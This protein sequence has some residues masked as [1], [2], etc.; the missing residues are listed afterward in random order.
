MKRMISLSLAAMLAACSSAPPQQT[1]MPPSVSVQPMPTRDIDGLMLYYEQLEKIPAPGLETE[2]QNTSLA[3]SKTGSDSSRMRLSL[4]LWLPGTP[5]RNPQAALDLL[6]TKPILDPSLRSFA[7]I[8]AAMLAEQQDSENA[9]HRL[10]LML[11][12]EKKHS[13]A[14]QD[15][16]DAVKKM[17]KALIH[18]EKQ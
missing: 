7:D 14:L 6:K 9:Q 2:Y 15:K 18:M 13:A 3:Y 10:E 1:M 5:F 8:F 17:E 4:L 11:K 16:I 12:E